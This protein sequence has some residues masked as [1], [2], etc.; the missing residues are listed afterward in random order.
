MT[1]TIRTGRKKFSL[2]PSHKPLD[3]E[4]VKMEPQTFLMRGRLGLAGTLNSLTR[5]N[6]FLYTGNHSPPSIH[7]PRAYS[8]LQHLFHCSFPIWNQD[9]A[10][11]GWEAPLEKPAQNTKQ[12]GGKR[13]WGIGKEYPNNPEIQRK[14]PT[15]REDEKWCRDQSVDLW[16]RSG[17]MFTNSEG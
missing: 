14:T 12:T 8:C 16:P 11:L 7:S 6:T 17:F 4:E 3:G 2:C 13:V 5:R 10:W 15:E 9:N 1:E